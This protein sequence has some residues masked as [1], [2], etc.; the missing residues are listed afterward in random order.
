MVILRVVE[1]TF[2]EFLQ[3]RKTWDDALCRSIDNNVFLTW[4][5]LSSWWRIFGKERDFHL[6]TVADGERLL[7]AAPLM[8]SEYN[9]SRLKLRK[10]EF[11]GSPDSDYHTFLLT[12][13]KLEHVR[14]MIE[15]TGERTNWDSVEFHEIPEDSNTAEFLTMLKKPLFKARMQ[16]VCPYSTL[17]NQFNDY[18]IKLDRKVRGELH[19]CEKRLREENNI[20]FRICNKI[21]DVREA[22]RTFIDLHEKRWRSKKQSGSFSSKK[23][24][25]NFHL[26]VAQLFAERGWLSLSFT[27]V[28]DM[29]VACSYDFTYGQKLYGYLSGFDPS[30]AKY[31]IG[32][33][34]LMY[35]IEHCI[36]NNLRE[37][38][39]MRGD[40]PYKKK[41]NTKV[42]RNLEFWTAKRRFVPLFYNL[43][44]KN[45]NFAFLVDHSSFISYIKRSLLS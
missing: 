29:P 21:T 8:I 2:E 39:F 24:F 33:I 28:N 23:N 27:T 32:D 9:V 45:D 4:E 43:I 1:V 17:P 26:E 5:W 18:L 6:I 7:A 16:H 3:L 19:R 37:I 35:L 38:D 30:Y 42:R 15:Y 41:W 34:N 13:K 10:L 31:G 44:N 20:G 36:K 11:I 14:M 12:E 22:M 25:A 40:E